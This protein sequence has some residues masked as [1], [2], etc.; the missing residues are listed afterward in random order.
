[1]S[2][3]NV[4]A[5]WVKLQYLLGRVANPRSSD[6]QR[7]A[8]FR[9]LRAAARDLDLLSEDNPLVERDLRAAL[10]PLTSARLSG[11][12]RGLGAVAVC[13]AALIIL[14]RSLFSDDT[15]DLRPADI[16]ATEHCYWLV[17]VACWSGSF[18]LLDHLEAQGQRLPAQ[19]VSVSASQCLPT[20][21]EQGHKA[22]VERI[23]QK[24]FSS[25]LE[26]NGDSSCPIF[27]AISV[28]D[29]TTINLMVELMDRSPTDRRFFYALRMRHPVYCQPKEYV[30]ILQRLLPILPALRGVEKSLL[31]SSVAQAGGPAGIDLLT[32]FNLLSTHVLRQTYD[33]FSALDYPARE[34]DVM[35]IQKL[36]EVGYLNEDDSPER[37]AIARAARI[38]LSFGHMD[39]FDELRKHSPRLDEAE[40]IPHLAGVDGTLHHL[41]KLSKVAGERRYTGHYCRTASAAFCPYQETLGQAALERAIQALKPDNVK[42]IL[43]MGIRLARRHDVVHISWSYSRSHRRDFLATQRVLTTYGLPKIELDI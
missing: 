22:M 1:M 43:D 16:E 33:K 15:P 28:G 23:L 42:Y 29:I 25:V 5:H 30:A 36:I 6:H 39:V 26:H 10:S 20:A 19:V 18:A 32:R 7:L 27:S 11:V 37:I 40:W 35:V 3:R 41:Q 21:I 31:T 38:A 12:E 34:G 9:H 4:N 8:L 24:G 13:E 14:R 17:N 2:I